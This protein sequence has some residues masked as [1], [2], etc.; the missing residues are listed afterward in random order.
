MQ[1]NNQLIAVTGALGFIGS[2]LTEKLANT[3]YK[4]IAIDNQSR[5]R[6]FNESKNIEFRQAD[7]RNEQQALASLEGSNFIYNLAAL[8]TGV[9]Y[10]VGRTEKMFEENK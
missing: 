9:D 1:N 10:D 6:K 5:G 8:N 4:V 2:H 7:L 3:G